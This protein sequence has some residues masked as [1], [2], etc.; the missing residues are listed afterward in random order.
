[1]KSG[2]RPLFIN[3]NLSPRRAAQPGLLFEIE[4]I[5]TQTGLDANSVVLEFTESALSDNPESV[6]RQMNR[7]NALGVHLVI[8]DFGT[9]YSSLERLLSYPI[10]GVKIAGAFM[11]FLG[12]ETRQGKLV[13]TILGMAR[14]MGLNVTA[15][16]V[17][18][19]SQLTFLK[20]MG[21]SLIHISEPTRPY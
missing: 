14:A 11:P 15:E 5:L 9:G 12:K 3:I 2:E 21:L 13:P 8:D 1:M 18:T 16:G 4:E 20:E 7:I 17:E 19:E 6:G 10:E